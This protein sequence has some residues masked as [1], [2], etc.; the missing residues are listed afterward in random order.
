[1][2]GL[3]VPA[4]HEVLNQPQPLINYNLAEQNTPLVEWM[5]RELN[6]ESIQLAVGLGEELNGE[7]QEW[8]RLANENPPKLTTHDRYGHRIDEVEFHPAWHSLMQLAKQHGVHSLAWTEDKQSHATRAAV[9]YTY[10]QIEQGTM[11]PLGMTHSAVPTLKK[12]PELADQWLPKLF[13]NSYEPNLLPAEQQS[14]ALC[15]MAMTEKQGGSDVRTNTTEAV[16]LNGGGPGA[17]YTITGHKWFCSAP[18]CDIFLVLAKTAEGPS[19]FLV[20]RILPDGSRNV[21]NL[22]RLKDKL[23]N[24]SNASSEVEFDGTWGQLVGDPGKGVATIIEMVNLTRLDCILSSSALMR[25]GVANAT[26]HAAQRKV[27]GKWLI[28]QPLM[29]NVLAD[30][31][32][33]SEAAMLTGLRLAQSCD[34]DDPT[35]KLF[36]RVAN[37]VSKYWICKRTVRHTGEALE[38]L[39]GAG[40][41]EESGMPRNFREAPLNSV[42][43][44]SGNVNCLDVFRALAKEPAVVESFFTELDLATGSSTAYDQQLVKLKDRFKAGSFEESQSRQV[45]ESMALLLQSSL[46]LRYSTNACAD[47]FCSSR[48]GN[49]GGL[50]FGTLPASADFKAI[51]ERHRPKL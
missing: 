28:D 15:G 43:E 4:T 23:G 9:M 49:G 35:E 41:V 3:P 38:C 26:H 29:Q 13:D 31:C 6:E 16:P 51:V 18:M 33:E 34:A 11:C 39:G 47:L 48:L 17:E 7:H 14:S 12:Q 22:Q 5:K 37:A 44:G 36:R 40:Y 42:W 20:P 25:S 21:F 30:L 2:K 19:C 8:A 10:A 45:V 50:E 32:I 27:F 1:L 46:M 24:H